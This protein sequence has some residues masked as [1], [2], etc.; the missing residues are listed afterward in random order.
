MDADPVLKRWV[1]LVVNVDRDRVLL[2]Q[3]LE[4]LSVDTEAEVENVPLRLGCGKKAFAV[5]SGAADE[6]CWWSRSCSS[7][8]TEEAV[9]YRKRQGTPDRSSV[10]GGAGDQRIESNH[11]INVE[12]IDAAQIAESTLEVIV[13]DLAALT[14]RQR[15]S[16]EPKDRAR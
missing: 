15:F 12:G 9:S 16:Q 13:N 6:E 14:T 11:A 8:R 2:R 5:W 4:M 10:I 7:D 1:R 3:L